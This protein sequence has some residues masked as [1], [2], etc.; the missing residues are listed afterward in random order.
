MA[1]ILKLEKQ[2]SV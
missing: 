1:L 2:L